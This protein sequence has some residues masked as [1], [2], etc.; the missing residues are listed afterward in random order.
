MDNN[1]SKYG[2]RYD[3]QFKENAVALVQSGRTITEVARDLGLSHW[4][5]GR[6][7]KDTQAGRSLGQPKSL[8]APPPSS[9]NCAGSSRKST[10]CA[11][12]EIS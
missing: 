4:S 12:S 6:W 9:A 5:L 2:R 1:I 10:T 3:R 11:A 7:I 8:A